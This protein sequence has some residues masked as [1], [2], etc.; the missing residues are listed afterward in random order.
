LRTKVILNPFADHGRAF[1][2]VDSIRKKCQAYTPTDLMLTEHAG[3]ATE[4]AR[5][6]IDKGYELV[7]AAGGDGTIHEIVNGL[8]VDGK[9]L[10][11][12]GLIPIGSG[13][14]FA[15]GLGLFADMDSAI[16]KIFTGSAKLIDVAQIADNRGRQ[17]YVANGLG[18]GFDATVSIQSRTITRVHG[19]ALYA[20]A[21]L[22]TIAFYYQTPHLKIQFDNDSVEQ[23]ALLLAIGVG[24]RIGGGF[25]LT[26]DAVFDDG[27]LDSCLVDPMN[28]ALMLRLL[29]EA[30]RGTHVSSNHV[31]MRRNKRIELTS[32]IALP[33]HVDGE[34]FAY[35]EDSV[36]QVS[37]STFQSALPIMYGDG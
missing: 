32:D 27:L 31:S 3:H 25:H 7:I 36:S 21:A 16:E 6:A 33:I 20:L 10:T 17:E 1:E 30:M 28:R 13:N 9:S 8:M 19:F 2:S 12:L 18:I 26:P 14:D 5:D 34:I 37:I 22:R 23:D 35:H 11:K 29:P 4:L 24:P 15:Y